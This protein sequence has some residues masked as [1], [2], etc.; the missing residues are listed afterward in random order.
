M[1]L[2]DIESKWENANWCVAKDRILNLNYALYDLNLG[3]WIIVY[4]NANYHPSINI[5]EM[6]RGY[7]G[8]SCYTSIQ[9]NMINST[10]FILLNDSNNNPVNLI[11]LVT[12]SNMLVENKHLLSG[13]FYYDSDYPMSYFTFPY[14]F[15]QM[16][17]IMNVSINIWKIND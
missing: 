7:Y 11:T 5:N 1:I 9:S 13:V 17:R 2:P 8:Y 14:D 4:S 16:D 3:S 12:A 15:G 10:T 6:G